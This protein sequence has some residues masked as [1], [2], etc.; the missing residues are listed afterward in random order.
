M[1]SVDSISHRSSLLRVKELE[2]CWSQEVLPPLSEHI[3]LVMLNGISEVI[4]NLLNY[5]DTP[6]EVSCQGND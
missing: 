5:R 3:E 1:T 6:T 4:T 2:L